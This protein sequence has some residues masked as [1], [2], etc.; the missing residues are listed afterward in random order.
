MKVEVKLTDSDIAMIIAGLMRNRD[1]YEN[2]E[3]DLSVS[4]EFPTV[5]RINKRQ[6]KQATNIIEYLDD[7][8]QKKN[9][10]RMNNE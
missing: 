7:E 1:F 9:K 8:L 3:E 10:E 4:K 5:R 6:I 2:I